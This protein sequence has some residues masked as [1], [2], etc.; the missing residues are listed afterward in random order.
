MKKTTNLII[1]A[2]VVICAVVGVVVWLLLSGSPSYDKLCRLNDNLKQ[3]RQLGLSTQE[4]CADQLGNAI[5][6]TK[7]EMVLVNLLAKESLEDS[8]AEVIIEKINRSDLIEV[9]AKTFDSKLFCSSDGRS[10]R[11][12]QNLYNTVLDKLPNDDAVER[13]VSAR[14]ANVQQLTD[15]L[16]KMRISSGQGALALNLFRRILKMNDKNQAVDLLVKVTD[17]DLVNPSDIR[18]RFDEV[19]RTLREKGWLET[20]LSRFDDPFQLPIRDFEVKTIALTHPD[21][22]VQLKAAKYQLLSLDTRREIAIKSKNPKIRKATGVDESNWELGDLVAKWD[23]DCMSHPVRTILDRGQEIRKN[24]K[25]AEIAEQFN[26]N[27]KAESF[28]DWVECGKKIE[29]SQG[30]IETVRNFDPEFDSKDIDEW[31]SYGK[32]IK[33]A[34]EYFAIVKRFD[35]VFDRN[36]LEDWVSYGKELKPVLEDYERIVKQVPASL[37]DSSRKAILVEKRDKAKKESEGWRKLIDEIKAKDGLDY[38]IAV[39]AACQQLGIYMDESDPY[40][41][42]MRLGNKLKTLYQEAKHEMEESER[43]LAVLERDSS[44]FKNFKPELDRLKRQLDEIRNNHE[45]EEEKEL[46]RAKEHS[47]QEIARIVREK[48]AI[49]AEEK[50][51]GPI[52]WLLASMIPIPERDFLMGRYE[53][54]QSQW[55][56]IMSKNWSFFKGSDL[57]VEMVELKDCQEFVRKL[58]S[59]PVVMASGMT[60]RLPT[61]DEW[62]YACRAGSTG[63]YCF[64]EGGMEITEETLGQVAWTADNSGGKTHAVG[65]KKPNAFG[66]YDMLGNVQEW[67]QSSYILGGYYDGSIS[68]CTSASFGK[69]YSSSKRDC[70]LG[71]RLCA[72]PK[73]K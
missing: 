42:G 38:A 57:P 32:R 44:A 60:F 47:K 12:T 43:E 11:N 2:L 56:A 23:P 50:Q 73:T 52:P 53:V 34:D 28:E 20:Y 15:G 30:T 51:K 13:V 71:F 41:T 72:D 16:D 58:N 21:E 46:Q 61:E 22:S 70:S 4:K 45:N 66:L 10:V 39:S 5:L 1:A 49:E 26:P 7:D 29:K 31:I 48:K 59:H 6:K 64:L 33:D 55:N 35:P 8:I 54:T 18:I 19:F 63:D 3:A 40:G 14:L 65:Q 17:S 9:V 68:R 37:P 24:L 25:F 69:L 27:F 67:T 62:E 36:K